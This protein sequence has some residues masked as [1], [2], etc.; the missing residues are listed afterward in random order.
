MEAYKSLKSA[1]I[2][3]VLAIAM[4]MSLFVI[5]FYA[6]PF[7]SVR[8]PLRYVNFEKFNVCFV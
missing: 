6:Y 5:N 7:L 8:H 3:G 4:E 2:V 1:I